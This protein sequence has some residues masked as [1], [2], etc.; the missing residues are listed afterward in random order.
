MS[1]I[2][3][4]YAEE[5]AQVAK[6][7]A[8]ALE[9]AGYKTWHYERDST[10]GESYLVQVYR[11]IGECAALLL[12]ISPRS[13]LSNQ[14]N[15]E[16]VNAF[17]RG[18]PFIPLRLDI[19]HE[20]FQQR[21]EAW[22]L[23][24]GDAVS[25]AVPRER[26]SS[27][28][29]AIL[30]GLKGRG[31]NTADADSSKPAPEPH[32]SSPPGAASPTQAPQVPRRAPEA[33]V[34]KPYLTLLLLVIVLS[35]PAY[36]AI[37]SFSPKVP[38]IEGP[39]TTDRSPTPVNSTSQARVKHSLESPTPKETAGPQALSGESQANNVYNEG[40]T[41]LQASD[42]PGAITKFQESAQLNPKLPEAQA[43]LAEL[44]LDQGKNAEAIAAAD[45]Y[46]ALQPNTP[47]GLSVRY[48][49]Y[50]AM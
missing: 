25:L 46:L 23:A 10:P 28:I 40:V 39:S 19:T 34:G 13:I 38:A 12:L 43:I 14:V 48:D 49:A 16:V 4:S 32:E 44:Y 1:H 7:L 3:V 29:P 27:V 50:L 26:V 18:K 47:R 6:A 35:Y 42:K 11:A 41:R 2:F 45:R 9:A 20:E 24:I 33:L 31:L 30:R 36:K 21:Q 37:K 8:A 22:R 17:E 5:D 15:S